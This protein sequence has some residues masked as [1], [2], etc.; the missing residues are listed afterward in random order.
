MNSRRVNEILFIKDK[1]SFDECKS[2]KFHRRIVCQ[3]PTARKRVLLRS[4]K[5]TGVRSQE[6]EG[7]SAHL[8]SWTAAFT[9]H[10]GTD[11]VP[12]K[13][14]RGARYSSIVE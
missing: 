13:Q 1:T 8:F 10:A 11:R 12:A 7:G 6:P 5:K 3:K 4:K 2:S 9:R 14:V